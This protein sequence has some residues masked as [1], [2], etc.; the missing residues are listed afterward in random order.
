MVMVLDRWRTIRT[1]AKISGASPG[2][3]D[4]HRNLLVSFSPLHREE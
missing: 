4:I 3:G 1:G 2:K